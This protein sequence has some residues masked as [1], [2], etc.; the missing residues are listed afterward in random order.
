MP[1]NIL[2]LNRYLTTDHVR[3]SLSLVESS[4][5]FFFISFVKQNPRELPSRL[6]SSDP[7]KKKGNK[8]TGKGGRPSKRP[9]A[10]LFSPQYPRHQIHCQAYRTVAGSERPPSHSASKS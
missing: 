9:L 1:S 4:T 5:P 7:R 3:V 8:T 10:P 6:W 2:N